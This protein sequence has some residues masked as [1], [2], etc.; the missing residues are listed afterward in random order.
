MTVMLQAQTSALLPQA[1][2]PPCLRRA[3]GA[4]PAPTS[5]APHQAGPQA[6]GTRLL[7]STQPLPH[8]P[9]SAAAASPTS[10][11]RCGIPV[12]AHQLHAAYATGSSFLGDARRAVTVCLHRWRLEDAAYAATLVVSELLG[13]AVQHGCQYPTDTATLLLTALPE[14]Q[15]LI[16]VHDPSPASPSL[17]TAGPE[18]EHGRG[19]AL[20][21]A[22]SSK[23][24]WTNAPDGGKYVWSTMDARAAA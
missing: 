23:W 7:P 14:R 4:S 17:I 12:G 1:A 11:P 9:A 24:G 13:N 2:E 15:L 3:P 21:D 16:E 20:V 6:G 8:A 18:S 10:S 22:M 19:L 5:A